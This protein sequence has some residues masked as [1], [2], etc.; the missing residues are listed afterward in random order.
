M[1]LE[2]ARLINVSSVKSE[3]NPPLSFEK[4]IQKLTSILKFIISF[5]FLFIVLILIVIFVIL[6]FRAYINQYLESK[7]VIQ[8]LNY[9]IQKQNYFCDYIHNI[10]DKEIEEELILYNISLG[11]VSLEMFIYKSND[12][13]SNEIQKN[14]YYDSKATLNILSALQ[15]FANDN[16]IVNPKEVVMF[17]IGSHIGW[18]TTYLGT[19]K[20]TILS[21]VPLPKNYYI[22]KKNYCRNNRDFFGDMSSL[23]V[24]NKGLYK[25]EKKCDYYKNIENKEKNIIICDKSNSNLENNYHKIDS[26]E[27]ATL[28]EFLNYIDNRNIA[29]LRIDTDAEGE[30][31]L[32][33]GKQLFTQFRT[34]YIFIEFSVKS[35]K[36]RETDPTKF[37]QFFI[38]NGYQISLDGFINTTPVNIDQ[39]TKNEN[40]HINL[41][42]TFINK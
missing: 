8:D 33:T 21:F 27:M 32:E 19:Y 4:D 39:I 9:F 6:K 22:L 20:F 41:Y 42:L 28:G 1:E 12:Y 40:E 26:V 31:A 13:I 25:E 23:I 3:T 38:D 11:N 7:K 10:Y 17:D 18:Y 30:M 5:L 37:L 14:H 16:H 35:F 36:L 2:T 34:P 15:K 29:L 24:I